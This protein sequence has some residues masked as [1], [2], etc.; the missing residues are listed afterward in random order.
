[1]KL[2]HYSLSQLVFLMKILI[3][4]DLLISTRGTINNSY[5]FYKNNTNYLWFHVLILVNQLVSRFSLEKLIE[6]KNNGLIS[7]L[8]I[9]FISINNSKRIDEI[10]KLVNIYEFNMMKRDYLNLA[11]YFYS[12]DINISIKYFQWYQQVL[13]LLYYLKMLTF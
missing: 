11:K 5:Y 10:V 13:N 4:I 7:N 12:I 8:L 9:Y 2:N 3:L 6:T 1:M